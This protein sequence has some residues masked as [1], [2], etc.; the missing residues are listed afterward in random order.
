MP[1][2]VADWLAEHVELPADLSAA[3]LARA[4]VRVG[5]EEEAIHTSGVI[6][7]VVVGRVLERQPEPQHNGKT[8]NWCKVDVGTQET[9]GVTA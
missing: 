9:D 6:G 5:L 3:D 1:Y 4:L 2:I 7:P 8:I